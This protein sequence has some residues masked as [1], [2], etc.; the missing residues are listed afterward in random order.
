MQGDTQSILKI[1]FKN[2]QVIKNQNQNKN[3][4]EYKMKNKNGLKLYEELVLLGLK[5]EKGTF[6]TSTT[7]LYA[8][9]GAV[10]S[11]LLMQ[12]RI[13]LELVKKN[14]YV[15]IIDTKPTGDE[16][17][18]ETINKF[19]NSKKDR[20]INDWVQTIAGL[21]KL[22]HRIAVQLCNKGILKADEDKVLLIFTRKIYPEINPKPER[23]II[24]RLRK[25]IFTDTKD[26][27]P[28]TIILLSL[29]KNAELLNYTFDRKELKSRKDRIESLIKGEITGAAAKAVVEAIEAAAIVAAVIIPAVIVTS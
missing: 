29:A 17:L 21:K 7:L 16:I 23:E 13:K 10:I 25:A 14:N 24:E 3:Y 20:Y 1:I 19:K 12:E 4:G 22:L 27:D 28:N 6:V 2:Q 15:K 11:E 26:V 9:G 8:I 18:D 5:D